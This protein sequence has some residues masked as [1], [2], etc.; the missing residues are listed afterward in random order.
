MI[1]FEWDP[2]EF[3]ASFHCHDLL[4]AFV[5]FLLSPVIILYAL[6][7]SILSTLQSVKFD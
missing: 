1:R 6:I 5:I 4:D 2:V 3:N 7:W